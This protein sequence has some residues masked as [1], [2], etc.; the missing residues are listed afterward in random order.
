MNR[1]KIL[2][3]NT[4]I[5]AFGKI[6]TQLV[7]FFLL[8]IYTSILTTEE[9]GIVDLINTYIFLLIPIIT[10]QVEQAI[11]RLLIDARNN[12]EKKQLISSTIFS[13]FLQCS[14]YIIIF[15]VVGTFINNQYKYFLVSNTIATIFLSIMLQISRGLG[16]IKLYAKASFLSAM[17][18]I[19]FNIVLVAI[20]RIGA[21]GML[22]SSCIA[23]TISAIYI[24]I[25]KR[26][27]VSYKSL[28]IEKVK[29]LW[30][31]SIPLIPN[32]IS[33]WIINTLD[34][35]VISTNLGVSENGIYSAATKFSVVYTNASNVFNT[36]WINS[37]SIH[38]DDKD[39]I[40]FFSNIIMTAL[41]ILASIC[42]GI[43]AFMPF[44]FNLFIKE[45]FK[46]A[47]YQIPILMLS[48]LFNAIVGLISAVYIAKKITKKLAKTSIISA[49][50]N[51]IIN[52]LLIKHI[53]LYAAS[54][55]T[56][57]AYFT[58]MILRYFEAKK[59]LNIK[60][61]KSIIIS[62]ITIIIIL[63]ISYYSRI[64]IL[65]IVTLI[66]TI[67]YTVIINRKIII[68]IYKFLLKNIKKV[69]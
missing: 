43:I 20:I 52:L 47:Y 19:I 2:L 63:F 58:M 25:K 60:I 54:I 61:S 5:I 4:I 34:R 17:L 48:A 27:Y 21:Y 13:V 22:I 31:Y 65:N 41:K 59:Y 56:A 11:F 69:I 14:I 46:E 39:N 44:I 67:S 37:A 28:E 1:E 6:C 35:T 15:L 33:W 36:T 32:S 29:K 66:L 16:D 8:P 7:S 18:I 10:F 68:Y 3:K 62:L 50:I 24:L 51:I 38:I 55:S 40:E 30:K 12:K 23:N 45:N 49:I 9:Y 53:G 64:I 26:K 57:L 42:I